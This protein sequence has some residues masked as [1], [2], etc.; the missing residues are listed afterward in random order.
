MVLTLQI[1]E[2]KAL[3]FHVRSDRSSMREPILLVSQHQL[4]RPSLL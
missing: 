4:R 3:R 1:E 2:Q